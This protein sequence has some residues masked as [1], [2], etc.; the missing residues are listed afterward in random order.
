MNQVSFFHR[1]MITPSTNPRVCCCK[2]CFK[3][4]PFLQDIHPLPWK[5]T[6]NSWV[7]HI[8]DFQFSFVSNEEAGLKAG[9]RIAY[10][11]SKGLTNMS[12]GEEFCMC[13]QN[14]TSSSCYIAPSLS[15]KYCPPF[16]IGQQDKA[17]KT[18]SHVSTLGEMKNRGRTRQAPKPTTEMLKCS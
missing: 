3:C 17:D 18:W 1:H 9:S 2:N 10:V 5:K 12:Q 4:H 8:L 14:V 16:V 7:F 6:P 13:H 15:S 11:K